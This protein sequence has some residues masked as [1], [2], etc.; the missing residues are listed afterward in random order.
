MGRPRYTSGCTD[1]LLLAPVMLGDPC[2]KLCHDPPETDQSQHK[3]PSLR[4][5]VVVNGTGKCVTPSASHP[6]E[7]GTR[8]A[9][10]TGAV[11]SSHTQEEVFVPIVRHPD[12][13]CGPTHEEHPVVN[14]TIWNPDRVQHVLDGTIEE[15]SP[16]HGMRLWML[17]M[18]EFWRGGSVWKDHASELSRSP[19]TRM[20]SPS[21]KFLR[22]S[23]SQDSREAGARLGC[24]RLRG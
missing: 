7:R 16:H 1:S 11:H 4:A 13:D 20:R 10:S 19:R 14:R 22:A 5:G 23:R 21:R 24:R 6:L 15:R 8:F 9:I 3:H 17:L 2:L 12:I 18:L